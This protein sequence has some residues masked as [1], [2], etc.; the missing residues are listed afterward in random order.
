MLSVNGESVLVPNNDFE[1][2]I[3]KPSATLT[4]FIPQLHKQTFVILHQL[5]RRML[6]SGRQEEPFNPLTEVCGELSRTARCHPG[7]EEPA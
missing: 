4:V 7:H 3:T 1:V 6:D 2:F 5:T